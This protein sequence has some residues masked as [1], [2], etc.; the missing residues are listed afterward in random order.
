MNSF[1]RWILLASIGFMV[2]AL[3]W[4]FGPTA[5][6][7]NTRKGQKLQ[8]PLTPKL[9]NYDIRINPS[10]ETAGKDKAQDATSQSPVIEDG[11][12]PQLTLETPQQSAASQT[13]SQ[14]AVDAMKQSMSAAQDKLAARLPGLK[15]DYNQTL[16]VPETVSVDSGMS[17]TSAKGGKVTGEATLRPPDRVTA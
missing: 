9:E 11:G 6:S 1:K 10:K 8:N 17:L 12:V 15:V 16:H 4:N 13:Q 3:A 7:Q 2:C 14:Q 5:S